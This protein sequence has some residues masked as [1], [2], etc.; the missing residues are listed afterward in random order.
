MSFPPV[1]LAVNI[2][3]IIC[4][5]RI[6]IFA[7]ELCAVWEQLSQTYLTATV[8]SGHQGDQFA[9]CL[10][11]LARL[12]SPMYTLVNLHFSELL[13]AFCRWT[14]LKGALKEV[15]LKAY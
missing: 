14:L 10:T 3:L 1:S 9:S 2:I 5:V 7:A 8:D 4:I 6:L 12:Y 15:G 11:V 13:N